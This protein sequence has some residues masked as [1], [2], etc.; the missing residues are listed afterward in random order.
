MSSAVFCYGRRSS[1]LKGAESA[2]SLGE[3][4]CGAK[5]LKGAV[6]TE[7]MILV[8]QTHSTFIYVFISSCSDF[9]FHVTTSPAVALDL[10]RG[11]FVAIPFNYFL[12][13]HAPPVHIRLVPV[14]QH[15]FL[16]VAS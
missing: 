8:I 5:S 16:K 7:W 4:I 1:H 13:L 15:V 11:F 9:R 2:S 14:K 6:K 10:G 12:Q 3:L